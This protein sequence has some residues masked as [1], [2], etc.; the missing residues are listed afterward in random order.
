MAKK[1][2][3]RSF[4]K[5]GTAAGVSSF[6]FGRAL[7][8]GRTFAQEKPVVETEKR[9]SIAHGDDYYANAVKAV[10]LF[11]G[12]GRFVSKGAKVALLPN[13]Q[14]NNPGTFTKPEIVRAVI[15]M[16]RDAG[17]S[18]VNVISCLQLDRWKAAG[19]EQ[20]ITEAGGKL[21]LTDLRDETQ[22]KTVPIPK[23]IALKE[24]RIMAEYFKY[25]VFINLPI[26]KDHLGNR[27]TGT[28]KNMMGLNFYQSNRT[29]HTG[30][31]E[32]KP[33][34]VNHLDQCIADLNTVIKPHLC[35]VDA[36][37][38]ITTNGPFGPGE[39]IKPKKVICG[40]DRVA[41]DSYCCT[42]W[43]LKPQEII[44]IKKSAEHGLGEMDLTKVKLNESAA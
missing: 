37:E 44:M 30:L 43:G 39:L 32:S 7:K 36:T 9:I 2:N 29:F 4:I 16:C 17:A 13:A 1:I 10:E 28:L 23:G 26:T 20:V 14:R 21:V 40:T 42:L 12:I 22:F 27:F 38:F 24:A 3:R 33:D 11:G 18:E 8:S 15:K 6:L 31:F 35:I 41:I 25:D 5:S 19:L 34:D